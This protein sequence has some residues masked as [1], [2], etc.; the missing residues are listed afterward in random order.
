MVK[1]YCDYQ[2]K[3]VYQWERH[4][5]F[6]FDKQFVDPETVQPIIDYIWMCDGFKFPPKTEIRSRKNA[7]CS[8][9]TRTKINIL[10]SHLYT[11][12]LIHEVSHSFCEYIYQDGSYSDLHGSEFVGKYGN[13]LHR[14]MKFSIPY[15]LYTFNQMKLDFD[16]NRLYENCI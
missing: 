8:N 13:L 12:I 4:Y 11:S 3:K 5:V 9:A 2:R 7:S 14:H 16:Q 15:L 10:R 6:P 1:N